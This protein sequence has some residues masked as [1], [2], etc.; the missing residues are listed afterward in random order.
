MVKRVL[1]VTLITALLCPLTALADF[2]VGAAVG[3]TWQSATVDAD[4]VLDQV[5][6]ISE[7]STGWKAFG[8]FKGQSFIG[9]EG[10]YRDLGKIT[11]SLSGN[12]FSAKTNGWDV[13]A[14]GH[15]EIGIIDLFAKA[16]A[17]FWKTDAAWSDFADDASDESGTS[18]LWGLG[19]GVSLGPLGIRL[20]W[21]SMEVKS[22]DNLSM[23]SLGATLGF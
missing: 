8:G 17:F 4:E 2:Y 9:I 15:I 3:N 23:L 21:E 7:N 5:S 19:A 18:F 1:L 11:S 16:G 6:E 12:E 14:L 22:M 13:E 20:E 10:G